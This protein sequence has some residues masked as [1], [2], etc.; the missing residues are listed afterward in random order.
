MFG[1]IHSPEAKSQS[2]PICTPVT[3]YG[4]ALK[5]VIWRQRVRES[6]KVRMKNRYHQVSSVS[7]VTDVLLLSRTM[8]F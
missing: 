2:E 5:L 6:E 4:L 3:S 7:L 1:A 8:L